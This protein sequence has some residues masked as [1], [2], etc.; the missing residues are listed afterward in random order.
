MEILD[1]IILFVY[2]NYFGGSHCNESLSYWC[3]RNASKG[4]W[5]HLKPCEKRLKINSDRTGRQD[6]TEGYLKR[7][8]CL[9][10]PTHRI[11]LQKVMDANGSQH[12]RT[13]VAI[14][15]VMPKGNRVCP[16]RC[17]LLKGFSHMKC[18][19]WTGVE[20]QVQISAPGSILTLVGPF[21]AP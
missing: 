10:N 5:L 4:H 12:K 6:A 19:S 8:R 18:C 14:H 16:V 1:A 3:I 2:W 20:A 9:K 15:R 17:S 11:K 7:L 21:Q 13:V